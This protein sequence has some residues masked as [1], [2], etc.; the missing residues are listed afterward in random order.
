MTSSAGRRR[1]AQ[2]ACL[3]SVFVIGSGVVS[4]QDSERKIVKKVEPEYPSVL[5]DKGI[6]GTVRLRVTV[7]PDGTVKDIQT[8]GGNAV[9]VEAAT[10]AVKQWRYA[11]AEHDATIDVAIHFGQ[12]P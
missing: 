3:I 8:L 12:R 4:S 5:R 10:R 9:L 7:K 6:G 1:L 11:P 2:I